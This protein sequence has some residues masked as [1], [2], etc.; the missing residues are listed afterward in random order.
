MVALIRTG[1][2]TLTTSDYAFFYSEG[3]DDTIT[4]GRFKERE[5]FRRTIGQV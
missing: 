5:A 1:V 3:E 4:K 2:G